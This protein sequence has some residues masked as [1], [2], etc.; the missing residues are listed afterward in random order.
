MLTKTGAYAGGRPLVGG[1]KS[2]KKPSKSKKN[3]LK[4]IRKRVRRKVRK[5]V[6]RN[7]QER[8]INFPYIFYSIYQMHN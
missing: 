5:K 1:K 2:R 3:S 7:P 6:K 8:N 4:K